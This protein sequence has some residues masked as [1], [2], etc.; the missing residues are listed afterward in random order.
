MLVHFLFLFLNFLLDSDNDAADKHFS[1]FTSKTTH[2][3][4][5]NNGYVLFLLYLCCIHTNYRQNTLE[6]YVYHSI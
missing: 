4:L 6:P 2:L 5:A 1:P 3:L